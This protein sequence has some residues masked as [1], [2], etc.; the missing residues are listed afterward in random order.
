MLTPLVRNLFLSM[1]VV[2][3]PDARKTHAAPIPRVGGIAV[4]LAYVISYG[5]LLLLDFNAGT[6]IWSARASIWS[7]VPAAIAIFGV[8]LVDDIFGLKPLQ[9]LLGQVG[10]ALLA[11]SAGVRVASMAGYELPMWGSLPV[12]VIWLVACTNA[13]NLIDGVDGLATGVGLFATLTTLLAALLQN[14]LELALATAPLVGALLGFLRFNFN[15]ATVFL[16]DSGSLF[17]GFL[18]G[19]FGVLWSQKSATMLGMT[20]PLMALVIPL[21]DTS[22]AILRRFVHNKPIFSADRGH[23]HHRLLDKGMTPRKVALVLYGA[24]ALGA[25]FSL[26]MMNSRT[27]GIAIIMFCVA[28]WVGVQHLGYVE[29]GV[30]GRMF[31]EGAFRRQ[32]SGQ[33]AIRGFEAGLVA[34]RTAEEKWEVIRD[35]AVRFGFKAVR[36]GLDGRVFGHQQDSRERNHWTIFI[37]LERDGFVELERTFNQDSE[38]TAIAPF[39]DIVMKAT[40]ENWR[41]LPPEAKVLDAVAGGQR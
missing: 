8:G 35:A 15:P 38:A 37:P 20:A 6:S 26:A 41:V 14:N 7:L 30:A 27:S 18:L 13:V 9:K 12:T 28:A 21:M 40:S 3:T 29:F 19:C 23:I 16:G 39:A 11:Y 34:A 22:L 4:A 24:C 17:I 31:V 2:D 32:L 33:V 5:A 25:V 36:M 10:A 1:G